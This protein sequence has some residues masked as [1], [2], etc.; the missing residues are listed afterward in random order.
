MGEVGGGREAEDLDE[1]GTHRQ[2]CPDGVCVQAQR[3]GLSC[4]N[5]CLITH[6][7]SARPKSLSSRAR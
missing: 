7:N 1:V 2:R 3:V 4:W 6:R 5:D